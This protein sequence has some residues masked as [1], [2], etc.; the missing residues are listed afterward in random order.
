MLVFRVL[1]RITQSSDAHRTESVSVMDH[2]QTMGLSYRVLDQ[3]QQN[4]VGRISLFWSV[5]LTARSPCAAERRWSR[6]A[7]SDTGEHS[8]ARYVGAAWCRHLYTRT[9]LHVWLSRPYV[10]ADNS[11]PWTMQS[12]CGCLV[13]ST[14][15][16]V[17]HHLLTPVYN[18]SHSYPLRPRAHDRELPDRLTHLTDCNFI[19]RMLFYQVYLLYF[20][21]HIYIFVLVIVFTA[22][23]QCINKRICYIIKHIIGHIR[24]KFLRVK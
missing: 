15:H 3:K 24:D 6:L 22:F 20:L 1:C 5:E 11:G 17:L 8:S 21:L 9:H 7:D 2:E 10:N 14:S 16:H 12:T 18:T 4:I 19:I 13:G 23:W